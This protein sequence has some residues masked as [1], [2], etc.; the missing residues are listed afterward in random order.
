M[1][2]QILEDEIMN[3]LSTEPVS[4]SELAKRL[5]ANPAEIRAAIHDLRLKGV[6]ICSG[7]QGVWIWDG[8]DDSW[9]RTRMHLRSR[10]KSLLKLCR[11]MDL[12]V[13]REDQILMSL[14][15]VRS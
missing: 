6:K 1:N 2:R 13:I 8:E 11:A 10:A 9:Q 14:E 12:V 15:E 5:G 4:Q 7:Q 3:A